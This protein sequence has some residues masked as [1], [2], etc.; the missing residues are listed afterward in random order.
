MDWHVA[1]NLKY[2]L[3]CFEC[4]FWAHEPLRIFGGG[5]RM[6]TTISLRPDMSEHEGP[7]V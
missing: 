5:I 2:C 4:Q 7:F 6:R 3:N 1:L